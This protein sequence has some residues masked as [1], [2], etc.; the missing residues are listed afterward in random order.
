[1]RRWLSWWPA[2]AGVAGV[3]AGMVGI[4]R[5]EAF[6]PIPYLLLLLWLIVLGMVAAT[7]PARSIPT[8]THAGA[9]E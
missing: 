3:V 5:P 7:E 9:T 2:V 6:V 1:M 8:E 4:V